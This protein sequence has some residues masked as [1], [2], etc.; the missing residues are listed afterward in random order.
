MQITKLVFITTM[1]LGLFACGGGSGKNEQVMPTGG[2]P[3]TGNFKPGIGNLTTG[4]TTNT[5]NSSN[6]ESEVL[7]F[8]VNES[9]EAT[10][11][12]DKILNPTQIAFSGVFTD[13]VNQNNPCFTGKVKSSGCSYAQEGVIKFYNCRLLLIGDG[14]QFNANYQLYS[15][16][17]ILLQTGTVSAVK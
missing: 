12:Q 1:V 4:S 7:Y 15:W 5:C 8:V 17:K 14:Y 6:A 10:N 2:S 16:S 9:S 11:F 13:P 3:F